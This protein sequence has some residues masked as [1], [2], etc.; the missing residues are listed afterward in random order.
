MSALDNT[1]MS[2]HESRD[3]SKPLS[4]LLA[5]MT[6][7]DTNLD[8]EI[9]APQIDS[10]EVKAGDLFIAMPGASVDGRNYLDM[11]LKRGASVVVYEAL[12]NPYEDGDSTQY[13]HEIDTNKPVLPIADLRSKTS[14]IAARFYDYPSSKLKVVGV[15]GT[16]G[17]TT[18]SYLLAQAWQSLG[19][20]SAMMG[21]IGNGAVDSLKKSALT[22]ADAIS[23][24]RTMSEFVDKGM[25]IVCMEVS[26]HGLSQ[27][28]VSSIRFDTVVFTNLSQDHLDYHGDLKRYGEQK[29]KLFGFDGLQLAVINCEDSL[30]QQLIK[31]H[32]AKRCLSYGFAQGDVRPERLIIDESGIRFVLQWQGE[33]VAISSSLLGEVNV[34]NLLAVA[35]CLLGMGV[36]LGRL[37]E[38]FERFVPPPGRMEL[39][40][41]NNEVD[42][43]LPK[44]VVD[45]AHTPD[46]LKRALQS[47]RQIS[48]QELVVVFGCGGDRDRG[49]RPMMGRIAEQYADQ[50][51]VT[52]DNPR[53]EPSEKIVADI[54]AGMSEQPMIVHDREQA[55]TEAICP[56]PGVSQTRMVLVAGKGHEDSQTS[57]NGVIHLRAPGC[58]TL[59]LFSTRRFNPATSA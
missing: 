57:K 32:K 47:L 52:D 34:S 22:T 51:I 10:R 19:Y 25:D 49:K 58:A 56:T 40:T 17:K 54:V 43:T 27:D 9:L 7:L 33:R 37:P 48:D 46:A 12:A 45:Y 36:A 2:H 26:S 24:Q 6:E 42:N 14:E 16:N 30:G 18:F 39:F 20:S 13:H 15:T 23:V 53:N 50:V 3:R 55:I 8:C 11:A 59:P 5:G 35:A 44:V 29:A 41:A 38:V 4:E 21:T 28:R 1:R 31:H